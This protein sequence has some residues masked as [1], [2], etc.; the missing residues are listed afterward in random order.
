MPTLHDL[1]SL[2]RK[3]ALV[4]GGAGLLGS[5]ISDALDISATHVRVCKGVCRF[6]KKEWPHNGT[7]A[8]GLHHAKRDA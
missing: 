6:P 7:L 1:M 3:T 5:E 4:T 2:K 8:W